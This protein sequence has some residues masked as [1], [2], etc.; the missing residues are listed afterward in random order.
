MSRID[1]IKESEARVARITLESEEVSPRHY[2]TE[3]IENLVCLTGRIKVIGHVNDN[4]IILM[5]GQSCEIAP[6]EHHHI[7]NMRN[8]QS[9]YLLIQKGKYDFVPVYS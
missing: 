4:G 6:K 8:S 1:L 2:H 5:A 3:V 9:E 7:V